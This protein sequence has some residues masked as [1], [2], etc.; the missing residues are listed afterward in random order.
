MVFMPVL[1]VG[2]SQ[3]VTDEHSEIHD[4]LRRTRTATNAIKDP[5]ARGLQLERLAAVWAEADNVQEA[6]NTVQAIPQVP[7]R[8]YQPMPEKDQARWAIIRIRAK[9]GDIK[10][11]LKVHAYMRDAHPAPRDWALTDIAAAMVK[12][13][14]A[15]DAFRLVAS[16]QEPDHKA[17]ALSKLAVAQAWTGNVAAAFETA[18]TMTDERIRAEAIAGIAVAQSKAGDTD[19]AMRTVEMIRRTQEKDAA[20]WDIALAQA[21]GGKFKE[22]IATASGIEESWDK[23][24]ALLDIA[25][26]QTKT[27]DILEALVL[28]H[29]IPEQWERSIGLQ[30][31]ARV[32]IRIGNRNVAAETLQQAFQAARLEPDADLRGRA[33]IECAIAQAVLGDVKGALQTADLLPNEEEPHETAKRLRALEGIA[34][35]QATAADVKGALR[36]KKSILANAKAAYPSDRHD[37]RWVERSFEISMLAKIAKAL[38]QEGGHKEALKL[39]ATAKDQEVKAEVLLSIA[40]GMLARKNPVPPNTKQDRFIFHM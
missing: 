35:A 7:K 19:G 22:A 11:A 28:A 15:D 38:A 27:G 29:S 34:I 25:E 23:T 18:A 40:E 20:L 1:D 10:G 21:V 14:A 30:G 9:V 33:L 3:G 13:G 6:L 24:N 8:Q 26:I 16:I 5:Y 37:E 4:I 31:L 17:I 12:K 39:A 36:T 32:Q 2:V